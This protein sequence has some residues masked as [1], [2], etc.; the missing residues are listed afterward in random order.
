MKKKKFEILETYRGFAALMIAAIHFR[1]DTPLVN[2]F[3]ANGLFVHFFFTLSG[4]VIYYNYY[5]KIQNFY[6]ISFFIKKRFL[7]LYPLHIFFLIIFL[8]IEIS[9]YLLKTKYGISSNIEAFS[10]NDIKAFLSNL[11]LLQTFLHENTFNTPSWSISAEFYTYLI[12]SIIILSNKNI[13]IFIFFFIFL[14]IFQ[15]NYYHSFGTS[16]TFRSFLDCFY[17][18]IIG[19]LFCKFYLSG[20]LKIKSQRFLSII[21]LLIFLLISV[22]FNYIDKK[23][24]IYI[25]IIFGLLVLF[26]LDLDRSTFIGK[27]LLNKFLIYLGKISYSIYLSHLFIFWLVTQIFRFIFKFKTSIE[28]KTGYVKLDLDIYS[29]SMIALLCYV[30]TILFS[31]FTYKFIEIKF[32]KK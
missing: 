23:L 16:K 12:F 4:F 25:P 14:I 6:E 28:N 30:L 7:R 22:F 20:Y 2:H 15:I 32:Y 8:I 11:L 17:C 1:L 29:A 27:I 21:I 19:V 3:F 10:I 13:K 9:R 31:H 26:S 18:F 24:L 5:N